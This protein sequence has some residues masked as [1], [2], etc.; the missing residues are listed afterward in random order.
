MLRGRTF[1]KGHSAM[2]RNSDV[3]G[4]VLSANEQYAG[5]FG[6]KRNL[7]LVPAR[8]NSTEK[9]GQTQGTAVAL[10]PDTFSTGTRLMTTKKSLSK[11]Y[12]E[13]EHIR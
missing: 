7:E 11:T 12:G 4:E 3:F 9:S 5:N 1:N 13:S 8:H 10:S 6:D 2:T